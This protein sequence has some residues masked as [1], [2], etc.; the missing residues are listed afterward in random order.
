MTALWGSLIVLGIA[1]IVFAVWP[2]I[3]GR[4]GGEQTGGQTSGPARGQTSGPAGEQ[5]GGE[6][7]AVPAETDRDGFRPG[8]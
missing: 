1:M 6:V 3:R 8:S 4:K 5:I 2:S 7:G